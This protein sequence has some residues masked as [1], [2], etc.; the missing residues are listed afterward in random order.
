MRSP[1]GLDSGH[2]FDVHTTPGEQGQVLAVRGEYGGTPSFVEGSEEGEGSVGGA[3][4]VAGD[5]QGG[6]LV[7]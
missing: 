5:Q 3:P 6:E 1:G 4:W 2:G 7:R